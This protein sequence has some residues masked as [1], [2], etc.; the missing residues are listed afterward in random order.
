MGVI[1][2]REI[3]GCLMQSYQAAMVTTGPLGTQCLSHADVEIDLCVS[4][5]V[6]VGACC[7]M[8]EKP[9]GLSSCS[10]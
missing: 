1:Q 7:G 9:E 5:L 3:Q 4:M 10:P 6:L 2:L 8:R